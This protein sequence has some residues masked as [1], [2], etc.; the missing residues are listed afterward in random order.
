MLPHPLVTM[1][2]YMCVYFGGSYLHL[3]ALTPLLVFFSIL[4]RVGIN[5]NGLQ[6]RTTSSDC[7]PSE[8]NCCPGSSKNLV[9]SMCAQSVVCPRQGVVELLSAQGNCLP[10]GYCTLIVELLVSRARVSAPDHHSTRWIALSSVSGD[11]IYLVLWWNWVW[12]GEYV[13]VVGG[14]YIMLLY[15]NTGES[16]LYKYQ[17]YCIGTLENQACTSI[18]AIV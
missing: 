2:L 18:N 12:S 6:K 3:A 16:G 11:V 13:H 1:V 9:V 14:A 4:W 7:R 17:C 8:S 10:K 15:R 5:W